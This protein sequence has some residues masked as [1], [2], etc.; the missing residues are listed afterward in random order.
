MNCRQLRYFIS[1]AELG[2]FSRAAT[3]LHVAQPA[4]SRQ[5]HALESELGVKLFDR[6][7][8][9]ATL[10]SAGK[11]LLRRSQSIMHM[12]DEAR[13]EILNMVDKPSGKVMLGV[14]FFLSHIFAKH[15]TE[16]CK[17]EFPMVDLMVRE[18]WSGYIFEWIV[19]G[20]ADLGIIYTSQSTQMVDCEPLLTEDLYLLSAGSAASSTTRKPYTLREISKLPLIV[21]PRP[22]GLR[23]AIDRAFARQHLT[24][25]IEV[26]TEVWS[27]LTGM[28]AQGSAYGLSPALEVH[29]E[30]AA[31][32]LRANPI[33]APGI[34]RTLC[35]ARASHRR[36]IPAAN[37]VFDLIVREFQKISWPVLDIESGSMSILPRGDIRG[38]SKGLHPGGRVARMHMAGSDRPCSCVPD[39]SGAL[40]HRPDC[41]F[42]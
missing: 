35:V 29:N 30:L 26:E 39:G 17:A 37:E 40:R 20:Q 16:I 1:V 23:L 31:G 9:G 15:A 34:K 10:T 28:V 38:A 19:N 22:H 6:T 36:S 13:A 8:H 3:E 4:V 42:A 41:V 18:G 32:S 12:I 11:V 24:P 5:V 21:P 27:V 14:P 2:G 33:A 25:R 7:G